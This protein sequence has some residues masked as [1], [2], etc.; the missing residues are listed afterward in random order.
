VRRFLFLGPAT[1]AERLAAGI[2][3]LIFRRGDGIMRVLISSQEGMLEVFRSA[4]KYH[5][6]DA[7]FSDWDIKKLAAAIEET[8]KD[9]IQHSYAGNPEGKLTLE[10]LD[11]PDRVEFILED[12]ALKIHE[13]TVHPRPLDE[14][15]PGA[16]EAIARRCGIDS[17]GYERSHQNGNRLKMVKHLP[18]RPAP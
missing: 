8:A 5:A 7:G 9:I 16:I 18:Q 1:F 12:S 10:I 4:V 11:F 6:R 2:E 3:A 15:C 17:A 13:K 14:V